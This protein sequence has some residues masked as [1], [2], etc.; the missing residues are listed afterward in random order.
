MVS[1]SISEGKRKLSPT[2][3][4]AILDEVRAILDSVGDLSD[5]PVVV[6][7]RRLVNARDAANSARLEMAKRH[8][9]HR[10]QINKLKQQVRDARIGDDLLM[11]AKRSRHYCSVSDQLVLAGWIIDQHRVKNRRMAFRRVRV[12]RRCGIRLRRGDK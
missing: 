11:V 2:T 7:V 9:D 12:K 6:R 1:P 10:M 8:I 4:R 5:D 3:D